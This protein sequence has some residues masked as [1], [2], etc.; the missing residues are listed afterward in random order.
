LS[1]FIIFIERLKNFRAR[2][3]YVGE[4]CFRARATNRNISHQNQQLIFYARAQG[5]GIVEIGDEKKEVEKD[6]LIDSPKGIM[7]SGIMRAMR[8]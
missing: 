6:T 1:Y 8:D 3:T 5:R 2:K 4:L 7:H